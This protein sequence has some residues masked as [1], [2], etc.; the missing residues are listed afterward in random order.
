MRRPIPFLLSLIF[1]ATMT[2][3]LLMVPG[4]IEQEAMAL[5]DGCRGLQDSDQVVVYYFHRKFVCRS[6]EGIDETVLKGL[7]RYFPVD[8]RD[9]RLAM[10]TVNLDEPGNLHYLDDFDIVFN[11]IIVVDRKNGKVVRFKNV[12][13]LWDIYPDRKATIELIRDEVKGFLS[14][15][16]AG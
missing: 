3:L 6:C 8:L 11:S 12:E 13:K 5:A 9:G 4:P 15:A 10:C 7:E 1:T 14:E 16:E 2:A